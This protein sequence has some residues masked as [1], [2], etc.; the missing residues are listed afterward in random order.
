[1]SDDRD[2]G[3]AKLECT[4]SSLVCCLSEGRST[5][6]EGVRRETSA[7]QDDT[8]LVYEE[9]CMHGIELSCIF[10]SLDKG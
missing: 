7:R 8:V 2:T 3:P 4:L 9:E 10:D 1:M 5:E 6:P